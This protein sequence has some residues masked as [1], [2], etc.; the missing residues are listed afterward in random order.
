MDGSTPV[1]SGGGGWVGGAAAGGGGF[2]GGAPTSVFSAGGWRTSRGII[3]GHFEKIV[4][5]E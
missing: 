5:I 2:T 3:I 4:E 1:F